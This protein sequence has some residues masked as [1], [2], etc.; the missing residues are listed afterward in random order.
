[1]LNRKI[2]LAKTLL[3]LGIRRIL[4]V[5]NHRRNLRKG[6]Y[7]RLTPSKS[8]VD[9]TPQRLRSPFS[10]PSR[11]TLV[12]VLGEAGLNSLIADADRI[13]GGE[14][15]YFSWEWRRRSGWRSNP[16]NGFETPLV[17]W[18][19]IK[20]FD[21]AQ[22]DIKWIWEPSR[23]DW[24]VTLARAFAA[25][26]DTRYERAFIE[27]LTDWREHNPPNQGINWY[28][29]QEC[30]LRLMALLVAAT[31]FLSPEAHDLISTTIAALAERVEPTMGYA[32]GQH[33]N[34]GTSESAGLYLAGCALPDHPQAARWR[35]EGKKILE[36]LVLEQFAIDGSYVQH[37]FVYQRVALRAC[38]MAALAARR[39]EDGRLD[40]RV[41]DRL[42][43]G[44]DFLR[45]MMV[46]PSTGRLPNYG[47]NDGANAVALSPC[48][49]LDFRPILQVGLALLDHEVA[50]DAGPWNEELLWFGL[51]STMPL[52]EPVEPSF[53]ALS[54]GYA[55][56]TEQ[57]W[58]VFMR[59]PN[60]TDGRPG[61]ADALH[62]D[63]WYN[64]R[65]VAVDSGTYSYNDTEG[66]SKHFKSTA[67]HNTVMVDGKDQMPLASRFLYTD[68]TKA[69]LH[70]GSAIDED[71]T[72][73]VL[74]GFVRGASFGGV[75]HA[76]EQI[77]L[78]VQHRRSV[79]VSEFVVVSDTF[80]SAKGRRLKLIWHLD[81]SW[82]RQGDMFVRSDDGISLSL[83]V[84]TLGD[85]D[86][87]VEIDLRT[88]E[89]PDTVVS[90]AYG[91]TRQITVIEVTF[92]GGDVSGVVSTF[93]RQTE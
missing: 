79:G 7:L 2:A 41:E 63:V 78:G 64:E 76:Y 6:A 60:Y 3:R 16:D 73:Q 32:I 66:W 34:H 74:D 26:G 51:P 81:G 11:T 21:S 44:V 35:T 80:A 27:L 59:A 75:S 67:A 20:D 38:L 86:P 70:E 68:W 88:N 47:A 58:S 72:S 1:M 42:S 19:Q 43:F 92:V 49:Y 54:G 50:F 53:F 65:P 62:A 55:R 89:A 18:S 61:Q 22:G 48:A 15:C 24:A 28:C 52:A 40:E 91:Q 90:E 87:P 45:Q 8:W 46:A 69:E 5:A 12:A 23:F 36:R 4:L 30:S 39:L 56:V 14:L 57:G 31:V 82:D 9:F 84:H 93:S 37:S 33:N 85:A 13:V 71:G 25:T 17:H 10:L 83:L 29:G 77:G